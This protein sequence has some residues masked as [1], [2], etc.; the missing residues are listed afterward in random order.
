MP[1]SVSVSVSGA[2]S[3][4]R[5]TNKPDLSPLAVTLKLIGVKVYVEPPEHLRARGTKKLTGQIAAGGK[6]STTGKSSSGHRSVLSVSSFSKLGSQPEGAWDHVMVEDV[7]HKASLFPGQA[8]RQDFSLRELW[9]KYLENDGSSAAALAM[10]FKSV[11]LPGKVGIT[12]VAD[13]YTWNQTCLAP[14]LLEGEILTAYRV[15]RHDEDIAANGLTFAPGATAGGYKDGGS[16]VDFI[17]HLNTHVGSGSRLNTPKAMIS[18]TTSV[19]VALWWS[20]F[21]VLKIARI[22]LAAAKEKALPMW[23]VGGAHSEL[24][25]PQQRNFASASHEIVFSTPIPNTGPVEAYPIAWMVVSGLFDS[26]SKPGEFPPHKALELKNIE[27]LERLKGSTEPLKVRV[28]WEEK[29][30]TY[31]KVFVLKRGGKTEKEGVQ[32][33][34]HT[35][36]EYLANMMYRVMGVPVPRM[37]LYH[38]VVTGGQKEILGSFYFTL[39]EFLEDMEHPDEKDKGHQQSCAEE[40]VKGFV[41]DLVLGNMDVVGDHMQNLLISSNMGVIEQVL[42]IDSG[43]CLEFNPVG[44]IKQNGFTAAGV[45]SDIDLFLGCKDKDSANVLRGELYE[46]VANNSEATKA[47]LRK[48]ATYILEMLR[49]EKSMELEIAKQNAP[50]AWMDSVRVVAERLE[51]FA[52]GAVSEPD[53]SIFSLGPVVATAAF[54]SGGVPADGP[55]QVVKQ[56]SDDLI[57]KI[58]ESAII[59]VQG[60][61]GYYD[62]SGNLKKTPPDGYEIIDVTSY[63]TS[64]YKQFSPFHP[65]GGVLVPYVGT[66]AQPIYSASVEGVWQGLKMFTVKGEGISSKHFDINIDKGA[67]T[68]GMK[69]GGPKAKVNGVCHFGGPAAGGTG[70]IKKISKAKGLGLE[71]TRLGYVDARRKIYLPTYQK[72]LKRPV[73]SKLI[74]GLRRKLIKGNKLLF[75]DIYTSADIDNAEGKPLSHAQLLRNYVLTGDVDGGPSGPPPTSKPASK[76][77]SKAASK[78]ASPQKSP[79]GLKSRIAK[80]TA[81]NQARRATAAASAAAPRSSLQSSPLLVRQPSR[82]SSRQ[83]SAISEQ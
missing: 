30:K 80:R 74:L 15:L 49:F 61:K 27:F 44:T 18:G 76:N 28:K 72:M 77:A 26:Q 19:Q 45:I 82:Q 12:T 3:T 59:D 51:N 53:M 60:R 8:A 35:A 5:D 4:G 10:S 17:G 73:V 47:F 81:A 22:D 29:R 43:G 16:A 62:R 55:S 78:T 37:G 21:G 7:P 46:S 32:P 33:G 65:H 41:A 68:K 58:P 70:A 39:I 50:P 66:E 48:Q 56:G 24:L 54:G 25:R 20:A 63:S 69:R 9:E 64:L 11:N 36:N 57:G 6:I 34:Q 2:Y 79:G 38:I 23:H 52:S 83:L 71:G 67:G 31:T 42:R 1:R 13:L 14:A 40:L 75:L